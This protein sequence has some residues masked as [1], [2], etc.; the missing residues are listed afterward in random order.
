MVSASPYFRKFFTNLNE[1]NKYSVNTKQLDS[2]ALQIMVDYIYTGEIKIAKQNVQIY[3]NIWFIIDT[4]TNYTNV[5]MYPN[6]M[7]FFH[8]HLFYIKVKLLKVE[9]QNMLSIT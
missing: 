4:D 1:N 7:V 3:I 8:Y 5:I 6:H 2:T 9:W